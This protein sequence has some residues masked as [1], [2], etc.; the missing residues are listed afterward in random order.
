MYQVPGRS[1][2]HFSN[3]TVIIATIR[4]DV[5][6]IFPIEGIYEVRC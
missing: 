4:E 1:M 6:L 5:M 3:I 2:R